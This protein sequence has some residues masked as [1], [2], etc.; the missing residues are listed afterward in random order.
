MKWIKRLGVLVLSLYVI[1]CGVLYFTQERIIFNPDKLPEDFDFR[2]G[3]EVEITVEK[4]ISLNC[5]WLKD[6][7]SKGVILYLHGN[8]GSNRRCLRQAETMA[9]NG[10]DIFMPD[11]RGY[12]KSDGEIE[13]EAQMQ[14]DVQ[15]V[16]DF[17]KK[18][19]AEEK[20][21]LVGYSLGSGM[22]TWLASNNHPQQ[23]LL[24]APYTSMVDLKNRMVP[25][26]PDFVLKYPL[27]SEDYLRR[28]DVPVTM[29]H[30]TS[31]EVIP[32][33]SSEKLQALNPDLFHLISMHEGHRGVIFSPVFRQKVGELLF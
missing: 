22:A 2:M 15:Q 1:F 9:G 11:Y 25:F 28:V 10:Y 31:D 7:H 14:S 21:V 23:L 17:L 19:Y 30:G 20:I 27:K 29:F 26:V 12:G 4:D 5:L 32:F 16:Y 8:R 13:S 24:L 18:H 3:E 33:E 6:P